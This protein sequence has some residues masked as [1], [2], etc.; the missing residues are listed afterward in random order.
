MFY[1]RQKVCRFEKWIGI[2]WLSQLWW[3]SYWRCSLTAFIVIHLI[4]VLVLELSQSY[5]DM[6]KVKL[7]NISLCISCI[8]KRNRNWFIIFYLIDFLVSWTLV[9]HT[10]IF[11]SFRLLDIRFYWQQFRS[12]TKNCPVT[13]PCCFGYHRYNNYRYTEALVC[14]SDCMMNLFFSQFNYLYYFNREDVPDSNQPDFM[15]VRF[16]MSKESLL[17][18]NVCDQKL[19]I[20]RGIV[21]FGILLAIK[22]WQARLIMYSQRITKTMELFTAVKAFY[23]AIVVPLPSFPVARL[24]IYHIPTRF[25]SS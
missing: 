14:Y 1:S 16:P 22:V 20:I 6:S 11:N 10:E 17:K 5:F 3:H 7:E 23:S 9:C 21:T 15:C 4:L 19:C 8:L 18:I 24:W 2:L 12:F 25:V 13:Q